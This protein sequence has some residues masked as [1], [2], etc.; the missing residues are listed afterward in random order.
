MIKVAVQLKGIVRK[1]SALLDERITPSQKKAISAFLE[2]DQPASSGSYAPQSGQVFGVLKN[3]KESFEANLAASQREESDS[4]A[5]YVDLKS[6]KQDEITAGQTQVSDKSLQ[7]GN[8]DEK[9]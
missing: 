7:L 1:H 2:V 4:A 5:A 6:A 9:L 3:M 8:T